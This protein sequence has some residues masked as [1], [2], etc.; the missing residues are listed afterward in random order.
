[1]EAI[2]AVEMDVVIGGG[3]WR[4]QYAGGAMSVLQALDRQHGIKVIQRYS[5]SSIGALT[6]AYF[7]S[8]TSYID[9]AASHTAFQDLWKP[10]RFW[11]AGS[12]LIGMLDSALGPDAYKLCSNRVHINIS[13]FTTPPRAVL[14]SEFA[15]QETLIQALVT[16]ASLPGYTGKFPYTQWG[17]VRAL[18]G[19]ITNNLPLFDDGVRAQLSINLGWMEHGLL[20][21]LTPVGPFRDL[22]TN[23]Q[24]DVMTVL[25]SYLRGESGSRVGCL[26][27]FEVGRVKRMDTWWRYA[28][29]RWDHD[30]VP[31]CTGMAGHYRK[32]VVSVL[33]RFVGL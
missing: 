25:T 23:G 1:M 30:V 22:V 11:R 21:T 16:S 8:T 7:A 2:K 13:T 6:V 3:G 14:V 18:D 33:R 10:S 17:D 9:Y 32:Q 12:V 24:D 20:H 15:D 26:E 28:V 31:C 29:H 5:G 19:G 27:M 4:G